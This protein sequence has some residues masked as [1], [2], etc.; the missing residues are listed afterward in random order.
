MKHAKILLS[1]TVLILFSCSV[2]SQKSFFK[3]LR[4]PQERQT[5]ER[6][7]IAKVSQVD[8]SYGAIRPLF[9]AAAYSLPDRHLM[10]GIGL[11]YQNITYNYAT[12]KSY[13][14]FSVNAV[15]FAG[16]A[17]APKNAGEVVSWGLMIGAVNNTV[18]GGAAINA[19]K[20]NAVISIGINFNN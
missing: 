6:S 11:G 16:G 15:G 14:N 5:T 13:C 1:L 10:S 18:M 4:K 9:V 12:G 8:S 7:I 3:T 2:F 17:I 19:G 20:V